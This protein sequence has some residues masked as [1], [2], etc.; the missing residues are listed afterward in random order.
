MGPIPGSRQPSRD[1]RGWTFAL[2]VAFA[3]FHCSPKGLVGVGGGGDG[4]KTRPGSGLRLFSQFGKRPDSSRGKNDEWDR[5]FDAYLMPPQTW[6]HVS[7]PPHL[8]LFVLMSPRSGPCLT[9]NS[10]L[11]DTGRRLS[12][13]EPSN[14]DVRTGP[15]HQR[16]TRGGSRIS[17]RLMSPEL[18]DWRQPR[19]SPP[20]HGWIL[21]AAAT[22]RQKC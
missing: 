8:H 12:K 15:G 2:R 5:R 13:H 6:R 9:F 1:R 10:A 4:E 17:T 14:G 16:I 3:S 22:R 7:P 21:S 18:S 11:T 19:L 20:R